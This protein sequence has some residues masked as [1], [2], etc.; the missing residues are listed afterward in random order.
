MHSI[1]TIP[2]LFEISQRWKAKLME[3]FQAEQ[4]LG[5]IFSCTLLNNKK[6]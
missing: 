5:M 4:K 1:Q 3:T 6:R 2:E